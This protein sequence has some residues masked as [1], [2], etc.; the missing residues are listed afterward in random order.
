MLRILLFLCCG[1]MV[2]GC[3]TFKKQCEATNWYQHGYDLA[4]RGQRPAQDEF[5]SRCRK[6]EA[7]ISESQLDLG[8]K[9]GMQQYCLPDVAFQTGK[10]GQFLNMDL[11]DAGQERILKARH[12]D[13]VK[14]FC[15]PSS[16]LSFG[17]SGAKYNNICP[18]SLE[19][20]FL[21]EYRKGRK[22]YLQ[23]RIDQTNTSI[24][25]LAS[26]TQALEREKSFIDGRL[27]MV[28]AMRMGDS[29]EAKRIYSAH[30]E[31]RSR[32]RNQQYDLS[33]RIQRNRSEQETLRTQIS[34]DQREI[35][36]LE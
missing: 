9:A 11:C 23:L 20:A 30:E 14:D 33:A 6:S 10:K 4:M 1:L 22:K 32:L 12:A 18:A 27:S 35:L 3:S 5:L 19:S 2:F 15:Q 17:A 7:E 13:G 36:T 28:P 21:S 25:A 26:D 34:E 24:A 8:F 31:E 16:A 29:E